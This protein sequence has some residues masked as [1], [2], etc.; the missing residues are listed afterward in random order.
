MQ[1]QKE[2]TNNKTPALHHS[3]PKLSHSHPYSISSLFPEVQ[4]SAGSSELLKTL[5]GKP[6]KLDHH[7]ETCQLR[8]RMEQKSC[9]H[10]AGPTTAVYAHWWDMA[11]LHKSQIFLHPHS[12]LF[13]SQ[14]K[15]NETHL[16]SLFPQCGHRVSE[17]QS[18]LFH[19]IW[20][21]AARKRA[22]SSCP[23]SPSAALASGF[24]PSPSSKTLVLA[25]SS[26]E[27]VNLQGP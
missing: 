10:G 14:D 11:S 19:G 20:L 22:A 6:H 26:T 5:L 21:S 12:Y 24:Y 9:G 16:W 8:S 15:G 17:G 13:R 3:R 23:S 7:A 2:Q 25:G 27:S 1:F 4:S 18:L